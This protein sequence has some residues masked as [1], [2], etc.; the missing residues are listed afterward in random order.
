MI[1]D[2]RSMLPRD[3]SVIQGDVNRIV[4]PPKN[5]ASFF[6]HGNVADDLTSFLDLKAN[7]TRG[8]RGFP[9]EHDFVWRVVVRGELALEQLSEKR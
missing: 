1:V 5:V 3:A 7:S 8:C 4:L 9:G 6:E 2:Y